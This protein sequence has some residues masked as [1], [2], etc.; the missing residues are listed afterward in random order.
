MIAVNWWSA[1]RM[2]LSC[3]PFIM[4]W[5]CGSGHHGEYVS[6]HDAKKKGQVIYSCPTE[7]IDYL[8]TGNGT[9]L[10]DGPGYQFKDVLG[11]ARC[12]R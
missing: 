5:L 6:W 1:D 2:P 9:T 4:V 11:R 8:G 10:H 3:F 12:V 7:T